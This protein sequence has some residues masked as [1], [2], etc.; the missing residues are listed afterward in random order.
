MFC[1]LAGSTALSAQLDP[2]DLRA[3][4][5]SYHTCC[6][7]AVVRFGGRVAQY[8]GDGVMAYFGHPQAHEDDAERGVRAAL[9]VIEAVAAL[10]AR[11]PLLVR[12]GIATGIVV[13]GE[14]GVGEAQLR[15]AL[16]E[17]PNLAARLQ[18][19]A[20]PNG[21]VISDA[22]RGLIGG[23]FDC[24]EMGLIE[25]K[26]FPAPERVWRVLGEASID[27]RFEALRSSGLSELVGRQEELEIILRRWSQAKRGEGRVVLLSGEPGIENQ[28]H[29]GSPGANRGRTAHPSALFL[30]AAPPGQPPSP[31]DRS[32]RAR[33]RL[34]AR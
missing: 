22:T 4:I 17:T 5:A 6:A 27:S 28:A 3:L 9:T 33:L 14:I 11:K 25:V 12:I 24:R 7:E 31:G 21:V 32:T 29:S 26:G 34:G 8:L 1:D 19:L 2:E 13:T 16:G 30:R 18:A 23:L 10:H 20:E 15:G